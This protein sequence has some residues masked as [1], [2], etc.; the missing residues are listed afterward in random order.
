[1]LP[2]S[3]YEYIWHTTRKVQIRICLLIA[4]VGP[5]SMAPLELQRRIVED[6]VGNRAIWLLAVFGSIYL[7]VILLQ[8]GLKYALNLAKGRVLEEITRDLRKR[9]VRRTQGVTG[10]NASPESPPVDAGTTVS[11]LSTESED[12]GGFASESLATPLLQVGTIIWVIGYLF[13]VEPLIA[14]LAAVV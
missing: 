2:S 14:A 10:P 13:W 11:M 5:L 3:I 4:F 1:M 8:G 6:A 9:I 12:V 7:G